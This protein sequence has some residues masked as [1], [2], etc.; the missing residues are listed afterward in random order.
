M[1]FHFYK[2]Y[3]EETLSKFDEMRDFIVKMV[4][5]TFS[6]IIKICSR[7]WG[8]I[9][10]AHCVLRRMSCN[11]IITENGLIVGYGNLDWRA[12]V[13]KLFE[14]IFRG[15]MRPYPITLLVVLCVPSNIQQ[16]YG[17]PC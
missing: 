12:W 2:L 4:H 17:M 8:R 9:E 1:Q 11:N 6:I 5:F 3:S 16:A 14:Q 10:Y 7:K 15:R 13:V